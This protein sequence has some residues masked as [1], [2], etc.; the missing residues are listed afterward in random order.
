MEKVYV[1]MG[2]VVEK[3]WGKEMK[4]SLTEEDVDKLVNNLSNGWVNLDLKKRR[5]PSKTGFTHY[6]EVDTWKPEKEA[7]ATVAEDDG[8]D[9]PF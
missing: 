1:G 2:K 5:E 8:D 4:L 6:L 9:L 7:E 3:P